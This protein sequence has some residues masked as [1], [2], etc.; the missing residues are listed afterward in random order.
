MP[1]TAPALVPPLTALA[2]ARPEIEHLGTTPHP[3]K[4][5]WAEAH[6]FALRIGRSSTGF[7]GVPYP[8]AD[9]VV[10]TV[11]LVVYPSGDHR[12][13]QTARAMADVRLFD[14][15]LA[16]ARAEGYDVETRTYRVGDDWLSLAELYTMRPRPGLVP[17]PDRATAGYAEDCSDLVTALALALA[18][19]LTTE[20]D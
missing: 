11:E 7:V 4:G 1:E 16:L 2:D 12:V 8:Y 3:W 10:G 6:C 5:E 18:D 14:W 20:T 13:H 9:G 15:L 17:I 19:A